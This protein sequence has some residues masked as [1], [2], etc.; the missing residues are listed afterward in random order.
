MQRTFMTCVLCKRDADLKESHILSKFI[1]KPFKRVN[2]K[3]YVLVDDPS[4]EIRQ[5]QDGIKQYLLCG[6][7]EARRS[8]WETY[9]S[10]K[11]HRGEL[12][13][14]SDPYTI[15]GLNYPNFKLFLMSLLFMAS[16][17]DDPLFEDIRLIPS[18]F[19][20]LRH[21]VNAGDPGETYVFGC[22]V[23]MLDEEDID[24]KMLVGKAETIKVNGVPIHRFLFGGF[25]LAFIDPE[26]RHIGADVRQTFITKE[27]SILVRKKKLHEI[28]YLMSTI[29][30][31]NQ[32]GKLDEGKA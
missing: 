10:N 17:S 8:K 24:L 27:G 22:S 25:S 7:C 14:Q 9:F 20:K 32:Q 30:N 3:M 29:K 6:D 12:F 28:D 26:G 21:M 15:N 4:R 23:R 31:L 18:S 19:E 5:I 1:Y 11:W 16:V 2:G 13:G